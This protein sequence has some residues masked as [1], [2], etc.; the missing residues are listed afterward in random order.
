MYFVVFAKKKP[1][2]Q[3]AKEKVVAFSAH[4]LTFS[5]RFFIIKSVKLSRSK[6]RL[7]VVDSLKAIFC[8]IKSCRKSPL[9]LHGK[10]LV[11]RTS[12]FRLAYFGIT[13]ASLCNNEINLLIHRT[14]LW[15]DCLVFAWVTESISRQTKEI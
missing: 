15:T 4:L 9:M 11:F 8:Q 12:Y 10:L 13:I 5:K 1:Q 7:V 3:R 2:W 6:P 14:H